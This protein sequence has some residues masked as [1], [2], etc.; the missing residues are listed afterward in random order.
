MSE[1]K[2]ICE[3]DS[4]PKFAPFTPHSVLKVCLII[5]PTLSAIM[6]LTSGYNRHP[7]E[8][9]H[10]EAAKYYIHHFFP[11]EIGDPSVANSYSYW[12]VSYLNYFWI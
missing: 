3:K 4:P 6:A 7:D 8:Y 12:G 9:M 10:F 5:A 1:K 11:P 2:L